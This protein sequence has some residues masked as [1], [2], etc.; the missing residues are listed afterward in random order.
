MVSFGHLKFSSM[1]QFVVINV[2]IVEIDW[3]GAMGGLCHS[4]GFHMF[5]F[6][7]HIVLELFLLL[8][9]QCQFRLQVL[10]CGY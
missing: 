1:S 6:M 10:P 3:L 9:S 8:A 2:S 7:V 5:I 4:C